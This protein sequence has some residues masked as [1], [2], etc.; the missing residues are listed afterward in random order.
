M[1][2]LIVLL[3]VFSICILSGNA[4]SRRRKPNAMPKPSI[5]GNVPQPLIKQL[6]NDDETVRRCVKER[7]ERGETQLSEYLSLRKVDLNGDGQPEFIIQGDDD[8][9]E[10]LRGNRNAPA[11]VYTRVAQ[12]YKL[13]LKGANDFTPLRTSTNGWRDL[14]SESGGGAFTKYATIFKFDNRQ[15]RAKKCAEYRA[16]QVGNGPYPW[17]LVRQGPC[18]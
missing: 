5:A 6:I 18:P 4:Q 13:L 3:V 11:W 12:G 1:E 2:N 7:Y 10:C 9:I 15:Y 14:K 17:R 8:G 16:V